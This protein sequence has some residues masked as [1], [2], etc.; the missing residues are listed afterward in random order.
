MLPRV[1]FS[2][3]PLN[4]EVPGISSASPFPSLPDLFADRLGPIG[5]RGSRHHQSATRPSGVESLPPPS[6]PLSTRAPG[7]VAPLTHP[8]P[9]SR[10]CRDRESPP[11]ASPGSNTHKPQPIIQLGE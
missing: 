10:P 11:W 8:A 7:R 6:Q 4:S 9:L 1:S 2:R 3:L 5:N